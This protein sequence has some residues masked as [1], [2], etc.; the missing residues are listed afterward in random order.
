MRKIRVSRPKRL[1]MPSPRFLSTLTVTRKIAALYIGMWLMIGSICVFIGVGLTNLF[2]VD[3][4]FRLPVA[5]ISLVLVIVLAA[6]LLVFL[7]PR[8]IARPLEELIDEL[9]ASADTMLDVTHQVAGDAVET[10]TAVSEA[11]TTV[12]EVRQTALLA[13]Q[14]ANSVADSAQLAQETASVGRTAVA[15][16]L[17]GIDRIRQQMAIVA[18]SVARLNEQTET[19]G[20][21]IA[22][23]NDLAEQSR[24]LAVSAAIEAS[25]AVSQE[26]KGFT[27]VADE[28]RNLAQLSK[29]GVVQV[30]TILADVQKAT[31]DAVAATEKSSKAIEIGAMRASESDSA[32]DSLAENVMASAE[33]AQQIEA[34][35]EQQLVGMDQIADAMSSIDRATTT[36]AAGARR[37]ESEVQHLQ[38][39]AVAMHA[40][41]YAAKSDE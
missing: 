1:H 9:T 31:T 18:E 21:V 8:R 35:T 41:L 6:L 22:T 20:Q 16:T 32:I 2:H 19:I 26:G 30:R 29:S 15:E 10:A 13:S 33:S 39:L 40:M 12:D 36:N 17:E 37:L 23:S 28:I 38:E 3:G 11:A 27:V 7:T 24:L 5:A 34:A 4:A 14:T 25:K